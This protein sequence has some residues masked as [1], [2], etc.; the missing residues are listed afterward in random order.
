MT[1][2]IVAGEDFDAVLSCEKAV[3]MFA[4]HAVGRYDAA[5]FNAA[6]QALDDVGDPVAAAELVEAAV[7]P[8]AAEG[9]RITLLRALEVLRVL[10]Q[11]PVDERFVPVD[12]YVR[13]ALIAAHAALAPDTD[14]QLHAG[15][16]HSALERLVRCVESG[17]APVAAPAGVVIRRPTPAEELDA[18]ISIAVSA[19]NRAISVIGEHNAMVAGVARR[20]VED[21]TGDQVQLALHYVRTVALPV[22]VEPARRE[23]EGALEVLAALPPAPAVTA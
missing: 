21:G 13:A 12:D 11:P 17:L 3:L 18:Q 7:L 23:V 14:P 6:R 22:D 19:L 4:L 16:L 10:P 8:E 2:P 1:A 20:A 9:S 5:A 15:L